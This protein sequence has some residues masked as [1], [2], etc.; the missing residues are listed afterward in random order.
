MYKRQDLRYIEAAAKDGNER[1]R[2]A[3]EVFV[4]GIVHYIG[5]FYMDLGLSLIH[6]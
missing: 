1:A 3:I 4:S 5:S 2:L 6:I